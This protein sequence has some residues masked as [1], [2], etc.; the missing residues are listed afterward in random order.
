MCDKCDDLQTKI[1]H[2][3]GLTTKGLDTLTVERIGALI[4]DLEKEKGRAALFD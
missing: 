4:R 3:R 2:Y 1:N